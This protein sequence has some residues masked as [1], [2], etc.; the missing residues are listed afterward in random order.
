MTSFLIPKDPL[1]HWSLLRPRL[2][3]EALPPLFDRSQAQHVFWGRNAIYH[4]LTALGLTCNDT[5]LVPAYHCAAAIEPIIHYGAKIVFYNVRQD[6][7]PD[8]EDIRS[9]ITPTSKAV[10]AIHYFGFPQ[11]MRAWGDLCKTY[12]LKLIEDCA[13]VLTGEVDGRLLGSFGDVSIF[14][15]RKFFP[16]YDGGQLIVN[17]PSCSY[18][19]AKARTSFL[20]SLKVAK[21][22]LDKLNED[23]EGWLTRS[24]S[25]LVHLPS[26]FVRHMLSTSASPSKTLSVSSYGMDF[27]LASLNM[28]MSGL[29]YYLMRNSYSSQMVEKRRSNFFRLQDMLRSFQGLTCFSPSLPK[30]IAP[31]VFPVVVNEEDDFH[32]TLR[33]KGIPA[34]TWGGV[35]HQQLPL[36]RFPAARFLYKRLVCLPIHQDIRTRDIDFMVKVIGESLCAG[37]DTRDSPHPGGMPSAP[38]N[39]L[40]SAQAND[41]GQ[42]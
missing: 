24:L 33:D 34:T 7:T 8:F 27:D 14:S 21:N 16:I 25:G 35:I 28:P 42:I 26:T 3:R 41:L 30:S 2:N 1:L 40:V 18:T 22:T 38:V 4:G 13:H 20:F 11:P 36:G 10:L 29:S 17:D 39:P 23:S 5:V 31:L 37:R 6:C 15:L 12:N 9:K 32:L 19:I